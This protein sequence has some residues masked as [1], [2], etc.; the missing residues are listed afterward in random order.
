MGRPRRRL[1]PDERRE[2]LLKAAESLLRRGGTVRVEDVVAEARAAKGTF[3]VYFATWDDLLMAVRARIFAAF[4]AA[5]GDVQTSVRRLLVSRLADQPGAPRYLRYEV[6]GT[7]FLRHMVRNI[8]G[9]L[10]DIG[11]HR[12]PA[13]EMRAILASRSRQRAGA[14]APPHG[15][16]LVRV[17]Y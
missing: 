13:D 10:V 6:V 12:W 1:Q 2:E 11:R 4:Q 3:Y 7:G 5:G 17:D 14:T 8:V 9:T 16:V 15:L